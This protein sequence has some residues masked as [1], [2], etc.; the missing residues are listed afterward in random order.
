MSREHIT[1][2]TKHLLDRPHGTIEEYEG[3]SKKLPSPYLISPKSPYRPNSLLNIPPA[4][5][6]A[7]PPEYI[8]LE[9][10]FDA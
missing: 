9:A 8:A 4:R 7:I 3:C 10:R 2:A 5:L 1:V 6:F